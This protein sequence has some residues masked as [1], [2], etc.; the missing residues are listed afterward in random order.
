MGQCGKYVKGQYQ[1]T[2]YLQVT[3]RYGRVSNVLSK[4]IEIKTCKFVFICVL[5]VLRYGHEF[6]LL[7]TC[8]CQSECYI[9]H[10]VC[11]ANAQRDSMSYNTLMTSVS[12]PNT[13]PLVFFLLSLSAGE[14]QQRQ[15]D[16]D[17]QRH[18]LRDSYHAGHGPRR[19]CQQGDKHH[20]HLS[21]GRWRKINERRKRWCETAR[22]V[23][24][25]T[26]FVC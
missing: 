24:G 10:L 14:L 12:L 22:S 19:D 21:D 17:H 9:F 20:R 1:R 23:V 2:F 13:D 5:L 16:E 25:D 7:V 8:W 3:D 15:P 11:F 4:T 26:F 6:D 18:A